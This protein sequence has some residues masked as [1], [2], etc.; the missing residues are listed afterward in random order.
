MSD[1]NNKSN[2]PLGLNMNDFM[3]NSSGN[4]IPESND[5]KIINDVMK[6][7]PNF[8]LLM[9]TRIKNLNNISEIWDNARNK[10]DSFDYINELGDLGVI[11]DV[12]N[13]AFI[14]TELKYMDVRS[15]EIVILFPAI[16]KMCNS[17]YD[18]Y[19]KNGILSAWKILNYLGSVIIQAKQSQLLNP[20][21]I[22]ISKEDKIKVY[23]KIIYYFQEII[24]LDNFESHLISKNIDGLDLDRFISELNYFFRKCQG[25]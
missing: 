25:N 24:K 15:K 4:S 9:S 21:K 17:K 3:P 11:N 19:F 13:F 12:L 23:D 22:D 14:K 16:I 10:T 5:P 6:N 8:K 18:W 7:A 1:N 20:G 2:I